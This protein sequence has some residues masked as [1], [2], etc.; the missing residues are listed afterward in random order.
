MATSTATEERASGRVRWQVSLA[1][2]TFF[3]L[4]A[5]LAASLARGARDVW[6]MRGAGTAR[7][8]VPF[9]RT[10]GVVIAVAAAWL[11]M[12]LARRI[13]AI[14]R[15]RVRSG[16]AP[17]WGGVAAAVA[18][19]AAA[20]VLL[21]GFAMRESWIL[22][23]DEKM[24][25]AHSA[26]ELGW[27]RWYEVREMLTPVCALLAMIGVMLGMGAGLVFGRSD[28]RRRPYWL[29]VPLAVLAGVLFMGLPNGWYSVITQLILLALEAVHNA[30]S[31][32]HRSGPDGLS[33]RLLRAGIE[34]LP[35]AVAGL[36]LALIVARDFEKQ[37][38]AEPWA[39]TRGGW[40]LRIGSLAAAVATAAV[41]ALA[42]MPT[43][44]RHWVNGYRQVLDPEVLVMVLA[45]F[46]AFA[47]GLAARTLAPPAT[48]Q[49]PGRMARISAV[50]IPSLLLTVVLLS[51][52]QCLPSSTQLDAGVRAVIGRIC[53]RAREVPAW[54]AGLLSDD[55]GMVVFA[56][57]SPER[58]A[59]VVAIAA[60]GLFILELAAPRLPGEAMAP[61]DRMADSRGQLARFV[62]LATAMTTVCLVA[63][64]TLLVL[65]QVIVHIR[66]HF[67]GWMRDGWP[68]PF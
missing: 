46:G 34:S 24:F 29:F 21:L 17:G 4:A 50:A 58:L 35:A 5:G 7:A 68:S 60:M 13:V 66:L 14:V 12:I 27:D 6:G 63:M 61:F 22:R 23:I 51:A 41:V 62:W 20:L 11:A 65:G 36:W 28:A 52:L 48:V 44:S 1:D 55:G 56:W 43:V 38:R 47:A 9:A 45:G 67:D 26:S 16:A 8:P 10:A 15:A 57:L 25:D 2:L 64:P 37:R 33:V 19:R 59:W 32:P 18:W 31:P 3:V 30:M 39:T 40:L 54:V 49:P 53:D 42:A